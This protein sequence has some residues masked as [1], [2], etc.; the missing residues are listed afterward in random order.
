MR[1]LT[2]KVGDA[3]N[4]K[5]PRSDRGERIKI[6]M[7][8]A[9]PHLTNDDPEWIQAKK[10]WDFDI[11]LVRQPPQSPDTNVL[12]LGL[13][14]SI[15]SFQRKVP[16][17]SAATEYELVK[18]VHEAFRKLP[19]T[20]IDNCFVTLQNVLREIQTNDGGNQFKTPR[21]RKYAAM[22]D[23]GDYSIDEMSGEDTDTD[24][25]ASS[26]CDLERKPVALRKHMYNL[27]KTGVTAAN[28]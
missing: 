28:V 7:D 13:W 19:M 18:A 4:E 21:K 17:T 15:Q 23:P 3:I 11:V 9:T 1:R 6:Q 2:I 8:N 27:K 5:W 14:T 24:E 10:R 22:V 25:D 16:M 20:T 12:D 26:D